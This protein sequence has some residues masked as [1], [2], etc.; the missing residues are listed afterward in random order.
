MICSIL[1][2]I[3]KV[4][5]QMPPMYLPASVPKDLMDFHHSDTKLGGRPLS[6]MLAAGPYTTD[7]NLDYIPLDALI[8]EAR[9]A[10]PDTLILVRVSLL[11]MYALTDIACR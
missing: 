7:D 3:A 2:S 10:K 8:S 11:F 4:I 1:R 6:V 9:S 5:S